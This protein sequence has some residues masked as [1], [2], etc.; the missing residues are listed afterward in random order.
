MSQ[1]THF[2]E[3]GQAQMVD[4]GPKQVTDRRAVARGRIRMQ[5]ENAPSAMAKGV[6]VR[7]RAIHAMV[8]AVERLQRMCR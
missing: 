8:R 7:A 3:S 6:F 5:Q 4:V 2:N 1:L